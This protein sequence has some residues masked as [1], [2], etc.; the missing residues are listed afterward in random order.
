MDTAGEL[1]DFIRQNLIVTVDDPIADDDNLFENGF[2]DSL[3]ALQLVAF[4]ENRFGVRV[5]DNDLDLANFSSVS[6]IVAFVRHKRDEA[7]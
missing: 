4:V 1:R 6:R 2:V 7:S 3:F 5:D